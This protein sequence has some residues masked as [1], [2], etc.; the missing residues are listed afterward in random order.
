MEAIGREDMAYSK[1]ARV[2]SNCYKDGDYDG[3]AY[4]GSHYRNG[5]YTHGSQIDMKEQQGVVTRAEAKQLK[6][7][8]DQIEQE[9]FQGLNFSVQD[10]MGKYAKYLFHHLV[11]LPL[12][13]QCSWKCC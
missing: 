12:L 6:S 4:G 10:F 3:N 1:L 7:R 11:N 13:T 8:K 5:H 9:K 2:R